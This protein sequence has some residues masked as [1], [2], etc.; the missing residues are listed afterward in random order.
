MT[1]SLDE[2]VDQLHAHARRVLIGSASEQIVPF[3]H[4][5]FKDQPDAVMPAPFSDERT[6]D[7]FIK[8][9]RE[10]LKMCRSSVV[11]Y[12]CISEAWMAV[13]DHP[14]REGDLPPSKRETKKEIV[15]VSAG[16]CAGAQMKVWEIIRDDK[17]RVTDLVENKDI[18]DHFEG[19]LVNLME[20]E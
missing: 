18:T 5:Q 7:A 19:R 10:A 2:M 1:A 8:A 9:L 14:L 6:K 17:G 13:Q 12:A 16:D 15:V 20:D 11:N 3:F 4:V